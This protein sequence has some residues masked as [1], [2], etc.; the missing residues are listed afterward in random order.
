MTVAGMST[1]AVSFP[2]SFAQDA[3]NSTKTAGD[4]SFMKECSVFILSIHNHG[5]GDK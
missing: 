2:S 3:G 5:A 4:F 1:L